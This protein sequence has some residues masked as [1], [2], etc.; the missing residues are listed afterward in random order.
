MRKGSDLRIQ[1]TMCFAV[2]IVWL[3]K[4]AQQGLKYNDISKKTIFDTAMSLEEEE[5]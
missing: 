2:D 4:V 3:K 1:I 5:F